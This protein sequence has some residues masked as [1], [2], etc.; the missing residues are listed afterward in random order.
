MTGIR[1]SILSLLF[2]YGSIYSS[3]HAFEMQN[4][5]M[6]HA[7]AW[8]IPIE[9]PSGGG[10]GVVIGLSGN[11]YTFLTASHV[12]SSISNA[13]SLEIKISESEYVDAEIIEDFGSQG[14]DLAVGIFEVDK[15]NSSLKLIPV[16]ALADDDLW[17]QEIRKVKQVIVPCDDERIDRSDRCY[18]VK[19]ARKS[20]EEPRKCMYVNIEGEENKIVLHSDPPPNIT[21]E[22][23]TAS[24]TY[25]RNKGSSP[26]EKTFS[27]IG[28]YIV[29]GYSLPTNAIN[30]RIFRSSEASFEAYIP[31]NSSGYD[32]AYLT[33]STVPGMSGGGVFSSRVCNNGRIYP[34]LLAIHGRSEEYGSTQSR[35]GISLGIPLRS[36]SVK[37]YLI[38]NSSQLGI[39]ISEKY[40]ALV[41]SYCEN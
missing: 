31:G 20:F 22:V 5:I 6:S 7:Q 33:S 12:I 29:A 19:I 3:A 16:F 18:C 30:A 10:S 32:L 14:I 36:K 17:S 40:S 28:G 1:V 11:S 35:S 34:G 24:N 4:K 37:T 26:Y 21:I 2:G 38:K 9:T 39:P 15:A 41:A 27:T 23:E 25:S 8:T 13:E